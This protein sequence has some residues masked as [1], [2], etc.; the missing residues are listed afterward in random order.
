MKIQS[1]QDIQGWFDFEGL[2]D[3]VARQLPNNTNIL[4]VGTW[5][6]KSTCFLASRLKFYNKNIKI[7]AADSFAGE[8][9]CQFQL[10]VVKS[11][12]GTIFNKFWKNVT[13]LELQD[14][15]YPIIS[16]SHNCVDKIDLKTFE[17]IFIDADHKYAPVLKDIG[18]LYPYVREGCYIAGHDYEKEVQRA[19]HDFF[20]PKGKEIQ[21]AG[22]CW[23]VRK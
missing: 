19:V 1:Y 17:F 5:L 10:D 15:I 3:E 11:D 13:D 16:Q 6:G 2:Y 23:I 18:S 9:T 20:E 22:M 7:Y 21:R 14:Y 12:G 4:E 8:D